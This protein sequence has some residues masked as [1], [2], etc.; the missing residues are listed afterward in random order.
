MQHWRVS[1]CLLAMKH[2]RPVC[3]ILALSYI[4]LNSRFYLIIDVVIELIHSHTLNYLT[5]KLYHFIPHLSSKFV[6][7]SVI[8][9]LL[10]AYRSSLE[11]RLLSAIYYWISSTTQP[12]MESS[13]L[14][15]GV[16]VDFVLRYV[17]CSSN[18]N[19]SLKRLLIL[20]NFIDENTTMKYGELDW[21]VSH[22]DLTPRETFDSSREG[23]RQFSKNNNKV[24]IVYYEREKVNMTDSKKWTK[25]KMSRQTNVWIRK[26]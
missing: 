24:S 25:T 13:L 5:I 15:L 8:V 10:Y 20:S 2:H 12:V 26:N 14:L 1:V 6:M 11:L 18:T 16:F 21:A 22:T 3:C 19:V 23:S 9:F 4:T 7:T 17:E